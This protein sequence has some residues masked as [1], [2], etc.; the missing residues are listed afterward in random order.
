MKQMKIF[1]KLKASLMIALPIM[2]L[3]IHTA[4]AG[5]NFNEAQAKT[6]AQTL[7]NPVANFML[8]ISL[9]LTLVAG[10]LAYLGH[11]MKSQEEK[12]QMPVQKL[13]KGYLIGYVVYLFFTV[14]LKWFTIS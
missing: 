13:I 14:M 5:V 2:M 1:R 10:G 4:F 8:W 7:L 3:N 12:E 6:D 9:P 11:T